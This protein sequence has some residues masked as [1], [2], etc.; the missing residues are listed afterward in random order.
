[1]GNAGP[2]VDSLE[3]ERRI[4]RRA[5]RARAI[6]DEHGRSVAGHGG[7]RRED[8]LAAH[9][10]EEL[11]VACWPTTHRADG[12]HT[13]EGG[14]LGGGCGRCNGRA[15]SCSAQG[16]QLRVLLCNQDIARGG[17]GGGSRGMSWGGGG[18]GGGGW[19]GGMR[20]GSGD[21]SRC[22]HGAQRCAT[23]CVVHRHTG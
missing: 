22:D 14:G 11:Q 10:P 21:R 6:H 12:G 23:R 16:S 15:D 2:R 7:Q 20:A 4:Q 19:A 8:A 17:A 13:D 5:C 1:M 3:V 18:W 9:V